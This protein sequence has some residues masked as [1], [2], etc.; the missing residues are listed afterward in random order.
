MRAKTRAEQYS[1][2]IY[3]HKDFQTGNAYIHMQVVNDT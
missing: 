2:K 1:S 3:T